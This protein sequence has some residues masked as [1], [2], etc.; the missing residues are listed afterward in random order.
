MKKL[1][2]S[3]L[4]VFLFAACQKQ[5]TTENDRQLLTETNSTATKT[6]D[7]KIDICHHDVVTNTWR[8][9]N[10]N[11]NAWPDHQSHG[12]VR[13]DDEDGDGYVPTNSCG[14]G[15]QGDCNDND[16]TVNPGAVEIAGNGVDNNCNGN[17]DEYAIGASFQGGKIAYILQPDDP[18]FVAGQTHGLIAAPFD[19]SASIRWYNGTY[20]LVGTSYEIGTG[21]SNTNKIVLAQG[22]GSYAA[23]LCADL[24]LNGYSDWYLPSIKELAVISVNQ[25]AVG[26]FTGGTYWSSS[27]DQNSFSDPL[28]NAWTRPFSVGP[29]TFWWTR[30]KDNGPPLLHIQDVPVRAVRS[31]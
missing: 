4:P 28:T 24:V 23:Q 15:Q 18:G 21:L 11:V 25:V 10:A 22:A 9:I 26:G 13:L 19:Q 6:T 3:L 1:L 8:I 29:Y 27:E 14:F 12:D 31:F 16:A 2:V 17:D 20:I 30:H 7:S 5:I